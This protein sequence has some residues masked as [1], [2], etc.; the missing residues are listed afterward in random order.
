MKEDHM[1]LSSF[2]LTY[3]PIGVPSQQSAEEA[4]SCR[5]VTNREEGEDDEQYINTSL[6]ASQRAG[7]L[8]GEEGGTKGRDETKNV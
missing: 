3:T 6:M 2:Y 1:A 7:S 5:G 4:S 8:T